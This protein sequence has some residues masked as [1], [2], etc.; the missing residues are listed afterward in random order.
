MLMMA[1]EVFKNASVVLTED[2]D[3]FMVGQ[4][5]Y[6]GGTKPGRIMFIGEV[7][8]AP[9]EFAGVVL[10]DPVGKND[11]TVGGY[12]YFQCAKNHGVFSR[13]T[14]LTFDMLS[15]S[16]LAE[17]AAQS[18]QE[19]GSPPRQ[20]SPSP[21]DR[22]LSQL[23]E[24]KLGDRV[25]V[26]SS[27]SGTKMGILKYLGATEF[28]P[29]DW[30]GIELDEPAGKNDGAVAGTRYFECKPKHGLFAP[31]NKVGKSPYQRRMSSNV[32]RGGQ[33]RGSQDS[34]SSLST[35]S[36]AKGFGA[37]L[38]RRSVTG[39]TGI[40][41]TGATA[42]QETIK[43]KE[44][45]IEQ[46]LREKD[47]ERADL[48]RAV[49]KAEDVN[50]RYLEAIRRLEQSEEALHVL[51]K[52]AE[53]LKRD[54][55]DERRKNEDLEFRL[56]EQ[57]LMMEEFKVAKQ[58]LNSVETGSTTS[59]SCLDVV[60]VNGESSPKHMPMAVDEDKE[61]L[62][63]KRELEIYELQEANMV[64]EME[65]ATLATKVEELEQRTIPQVTQ[66]NSEEILI[67]K[68]LCKDKEVV[69][70]ALNDQIAV[71]QAEIHANRS[72]KNAV[73]TD[74]ARFQALSSEN[75]ALKLECI[76]KNEQIEEFSR[77]L[78]KLELGSD[79]LAR[80][81][82]ENESLKAANKEKEVMLDTLKR[83][84]LMLEQ[85]F[86]Q[87]QQELKDRVIEGNQDRVAMEQLRHDLGLAQN[88]LTEVEWK[89]KTSEEE[90]ADLAHEL[91]QSESALSA[92]QKSKSQE[93]EKRRLLE[94]NLEMLKRDLTK[95]RAAHLESKRDQE[96]PCSENQLGGT[97]FLNAI[98]VDL[99]RRNQELEIKLSALMADPGALAARMMPAEKVELVCTVCKAVGS[100][101]A[102]GCPL[103]A[104]VEMAELVA[105][106]RKL[107]RRNADDSDDLVLATSTL[108]A[109][110]K[111]HFEPQERA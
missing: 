33:R 58:T 102:S 88:R 35:T 86:S 109:H 41:I 53:A 70:D 110:S 91:S 97:D 111:K 56:E 68:T 59:M 25:M 16:Q 40:P 31:V 81:L 80:L 4:R 6:V 18:A 54:F 74:V 93:E 63:R 64:K 71:L 77:K 44:V 3:K 52:Q 8:F 21:S 55:E 28:Q 51:R 84:V 83:Q 46:L 87:Y 82:Q 19:L 101:D 104:D 37:G 50:V 11:G 78:E 38:P 20:A 49:A 29:G 98:I 105:E 2:T 43:E 75:E 32:S 99:K 1:F 48:A 95:S 67:L 23:G 24:L 103:R 79:A 39:R 85:N 13:L 10:D 94:S 100:H 60:V 47:L 42:F 72:Q 66:D 14:R 45:H 92:L 69:V 65:I 15:S 96:A 26:S 62:L 106:Q 90:K 27:T 5:V 22:S 34:L 108:N 17:K 30:A 61:D 73:G 9:G 7:K 12:T 76:S 107:G 57:S 36:S 89:L